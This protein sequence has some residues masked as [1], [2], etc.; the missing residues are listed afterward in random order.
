MNPSFEKIRSNIARAIVGKNNVVDLILI[1]L[2]AQGHVL[3]EDVPG[4]GKTAL[5]G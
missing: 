4:T 5:V 3:I 1:A 2:V